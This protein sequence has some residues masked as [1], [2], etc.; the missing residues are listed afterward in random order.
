MATKSHNTVSVTSVAA[1]C[2]AALPFIV[3]I[4]TALLG[5]AAEA[6]K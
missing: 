1:I 2:F 5:G 4:F 3:S 6:L